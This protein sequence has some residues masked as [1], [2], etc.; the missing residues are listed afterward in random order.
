[1]DFTSSERL[2]EIVEVGLA[3]L[4]HHYQQWRIGSTALEVG[5][6]QMGSVWIAQALGGIGV[7]LCLWIQ[8]FE[9]ETSNLQRQERLLRSI[10]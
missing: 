1:M 2:E 4:D 9:Q 3:D 10:A 7:H 5:Q 6:E 8:D